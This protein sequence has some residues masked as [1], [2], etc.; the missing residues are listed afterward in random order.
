MKKLLAML[1]VLSLTLG[2]GLGIVSASAE[3]ITLKFLI[4]A[5]F[6]DLENDLGWKVCQ[7]VSGYKIDYEVIN[8]T[9]QLMLI[10][11][12]GQEYDYTYL[13][14]K[15]YSLMMSEG[16]LMDI[17]DLLNE[18]GQDILAAFPT[19]WPAVTT[20]G[21]IY[22]IPSPA[23]QPDSL[24]YSMIARKDLLDKIGYTE[25]PTTVE[26]FVKMLEDIKAAYP[27]MVPLTASRLDAGVLSNVA[28]AFNVQGMYQLVD[29]KVINIV[30]N[31]NLKA[32]VE[33]IRDLYARKLLDA[34]MPAITTNDMRSKWAASQAVISYQSWN[35]CETCIAALRQL[36]PDMEYV[37]LPLLQDE[38]GK[39]HAQVKYGVTAY[40]AIPVTSKH[41]KEAIQAINS[42]I[43]IDNFTEIVLGEKDV[44]YTVNED[45][46]FSPIQPAFNNDKVA[47]NVF[48][49]GFY[50]EVEYPKMWEVRLAKNADLQSTFY[51]MRDSLLDGGERSPVALAPAVTVVDNKA[52]LENRITDTLIAVICG[53]SDISELDTLREYW[54]KNGGEEIIKFYNTW[55][56]ESVA[57]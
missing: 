29:G 27:D 23:A 3:D 6:Y 20:D 5:G 53:T 34:E 16:A 19:T 54:H 56:A 46:T 45:G 30:D 48:V 26:G 12:S 13:N 14:S 57:K 33:V 37:V 55:Y 32:Y 38:G 4:S 40:G 11:T 21:R 51:A 25:Y 31:T 44:H 28:S 2:L 42:M 17:T 43:Q 10:I 18:Y 1:L 47:S 50:R 52:A 49:S 9:E 7:R 41:A 22:A 24:T 36:S 35:G 39:V 15:N 8:G